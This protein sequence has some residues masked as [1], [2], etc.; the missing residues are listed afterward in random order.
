MC[1]R[2]SVPNSGSSSSNVRA[3]TGPNALGTLPQIVVFPPQRA[4]PEHRLE[5]VVQRGD[6][7]I[8]P[9][10][11]GRTIL[12]EARARPRQAVLLRGPHDDQWLAAP[13]KGAQLLRLG[14]GQRPGRR[15]DHV[16]TVGQGPGIQRL[17]FGQL[18]RGP[19]NNRGPDAGAR[20]PRAGLPRPRHSVTARSRPPVASSTIRVG[21]R[22]CT[23]S[24]SVATPLASLGTAHRSPEGRR[25]MSNWA[26]ATSIPTKHGHVTPTHSCLPDLAHTGSMAPDN[27]TGSG[28]PGRDDPRSA[29]VSA[30]QGS[31][32]L[33]RPGT[34]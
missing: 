26:L 31:I 17:R 13:Q 20:R 22:G 23:R 25:A 18:A 10:H 21:W 7:R 5:V 19:G 28:S 1:C 9:R 16:G 6:A 24:T 33:S 11:M 3:H 34:G 30:D 32:G 14:V 2:V 8:E 27:C 12:R 4:G 15:A 29:P